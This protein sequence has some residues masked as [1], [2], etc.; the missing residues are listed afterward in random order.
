M[1]TPQC[2]MK[3][4]QETIEKQGIACCDATI[5]DYKDCVRWFKQGTFTQKLPIWVGSVYRQC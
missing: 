2:K 3:K 1:A 5:A 4:K